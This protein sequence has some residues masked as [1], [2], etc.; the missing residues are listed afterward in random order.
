MKIKI[1]FLLISLINLSNCDVFFEIVIPTRNNENICIEN[2]KSAICQNYPHFHVTIINDVSTDKTGELLEKFIQEN[3]LFNKITI[4]HNRERIGALANLYNF[5]HT[6]DDNTVVVTLDGDDL[7]TNANVLDRIA[8][9]YLH[10][11]AWL[12]YGQFIFMPN[13]TKGFCR[14]YPKEIIKNRGF[15]RYTWLASHLRTFKVGLFKKIKKE[16]LMIDGQFFVTAWD[17]AIM[18]P[19]LEMAS[20][21]HIRCIPDILYIYNTHDD[22]EM[23]M[24]LVLDLDKYV[25]QMPKYEPLNSL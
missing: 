21:G 23:T 1:I 8:R 25:R 16:D 9:E 4:L 17:L 14:D 22:P 18:F 12:T 2:L 7:L 5:I 24:K 20:K 19:M 13:Q 15:R 11:K 10:H 3:N 6:L